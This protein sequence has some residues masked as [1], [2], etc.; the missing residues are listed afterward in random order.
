MRVN[1]ATVTQAIL[2]GGDVIDVG[3]LRLTFFADV[4]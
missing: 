3:G 4:G 2:K 1:R